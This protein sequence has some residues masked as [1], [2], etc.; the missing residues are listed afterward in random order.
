MNQKV[1]FVYENFFSDE[2]RL[3]GRLYAET[4]KGNEKFSFEFEPSWLAQNNT[5]CIID[6]ELQP[7]AGRQYP[8]DKSIFGTFIRRNR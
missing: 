7:Y 8:S 2:S 1:V 5:N 6:P 4:G 3:M